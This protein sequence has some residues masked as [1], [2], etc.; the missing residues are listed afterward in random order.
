ML[1]HNQILKI[2]EKPINSELI[3]RAIKK[4][5]V[6]RHFYCFDT[7]SMSYDE[8]ENYDLS[9]KKLAVFKKV[10]KNNVQPLIKKFISHYSSVNEAFGKKVTYSFGKDTKAEISFKGMLSS[11]HEGVSLEDYW[12]G[13]G[14]EIQF[15]E[16]NSVYLAGKRN[17]KLEIVRVRINNIHDIDANQSGI[18]YLVTRELIKNERESYRRFY[19]YD[20]TYRYI[21]R[22]TGDTYA[23]EA[24]KGADG[25]S[26]NP[27]IKHSAGKCPAH[28]ARDVDEDPSSN[29]I[30]KVVPYEDSIPDIWTYNL[31]KTFYKMYQSHGAF[32]IQISPQIRCS[33][34]SIDYNVRCNKGVLVPLSLNGKEPVGVGNKCP[35]C[36]ARVAGKVGGEFII[37]ITQQGEKDFVNNIS[38]L[39][40]RV[41]FNS[42]NIQTQI[43]HVTLLKAEI[44]KDVNGEGYGGGSDLVKTKTA[45]E[46]MMSNSDM[47]NALTSYGV[48]KA[49]T[50]S[51]LLECLGAIHS[52]KFESLTFQYGEQYFLKSEKELYEELK[53]AQETQSNYASIKQKQKEIFLTKNKGD[54]IA[55]IR[56]DRLDAL[57][58]FATLSPDLIDKHITLLSSRYPMEIDRYFFFDQL[59]AMWELE[60]GNLGL[61]G[62]KSGQSEGNILRSIKQGIDKIFNNNFKLDEG[63]GEGNQG[64]DNGGATQRGNQEGE[65][66]G[67]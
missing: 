10:H 52:D 6:Y 60:N 17:D 7:P 30:V 56:Y 2:L 59:V 53:E 19:I 51:Y 18:L 4:Q 44:L 14:D 33:H 46:V 48:S 62:S 27:K 38:S 15:T 67:A 8:A 34:E 3:E 58:P 1:E 42:Q 64:G 28:F 50:V 41:D 12:N 47:E 54:E 39:Y 16:P 32:G 25:V 45:T 65:G 5:Q 31:F 57:K 26:I 63:R 36:S 43:D 35:E 49:S 55:L 11:V 23:L 9:T 21:Y 13:V 24:I 40:H 61:W 22:E 20:D 37:P 66:E 29:H